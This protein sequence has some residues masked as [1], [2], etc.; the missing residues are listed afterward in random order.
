MKVMMTNKVKVAADPSLMIDLFTLIHP[1]NDI[2]GSVMRSLKEGTLCAEDWKD[3]EYDHLP[4]LLKDRSLGKAT[5]GR[6]YYL[7]NIYKLLQR[8]I[9]GDVEIHITPLTASR[10]IGL[11]SV[12]EEFLNKY[13]TNLKVRNEDAQEIYKKIHKLANQ[14]KKNEQKVNTGNWVFERDYF[15][16]CVIAEASYCGLPLVTN[17]LSLVHFDV[18]R[19]GMTN[20]IRDTNRKFEDVNLGIKSKGG[21]MMTPSTMLVSSFIATLRDERY[22]LYPDNK[23]LKTNSDDN[24][25]MLR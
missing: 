24:T 17:D 5:E 15:K 1:K 9:N 13:I 18:D 12:E 23:Y 3:V 14:Y 6:Y 21:K 22:Y 7:E 25:I 8:I 19:Y 11:N 2:N 20:V 10:L 4:K 16:A